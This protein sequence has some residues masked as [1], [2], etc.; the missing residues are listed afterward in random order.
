MDFKA[1][2]G[3]KA[4]KNHVYG[5]I[6][7]LLREAIRHSLAKGHAHHIKFDSRSNYVIINEMYY[8]YKLKTPAGCKIKDW[9][10]VEYH[11]AVDCINKKKSKWKLIVK[12]LR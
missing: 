1:K 9:T 2:I 6:W 11:K 4:E 12:R 7:S 5:N 8:T 3:K 10:A